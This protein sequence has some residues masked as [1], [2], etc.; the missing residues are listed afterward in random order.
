MSPGENYAEA[1][2]TEALHYESVHRKITYLSQDTPLSLSD[3]E[4]IKI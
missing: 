2:E 1:T 4:S 3:Q